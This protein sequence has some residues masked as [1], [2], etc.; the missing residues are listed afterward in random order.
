M[1]ISINSNAPI[2]F[3]HI[4]DN[5]KL[6]HQIMHLH[7]LVE[8]YIYISGDVDFIVEENYISLKTG[9]II[10]TTPNVLH[11]PIIKSSMTYE[12]FYIGIPLNAFSFINRGQNP[13]AF[14]TQNKTLI[15]A[16][17]HK[18]NH[19]ISILNHI[20][21]LLQN[22]NDNN[23]F[24]VYSYL[25]QFLNSLNSL[26]IVNEY[27]LDARTT[28]VPDIIKNVLKY[29]DTSS[30]SIKSVKDLAK[31]FYVNPSYLSSLF[32]DT[33]HVT[34]KQYLTQ[35]KISEAKNLLSGQLS[36]SDIAYE[37]GFSSCSHFISVFKKITGITPRE[38]RLETKLK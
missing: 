29:I 27:D 14:I 1:D 33:T 30:K 18:S 16:S 35:K 7:D 13:L 19:I 28:N 31:I 38:Y 26:F 3:N 10:I 25:L 17:D 8:I 9:D 23:F 5:P 15:S 20:S 4:I 11:T 22:K 2:L 24:L 32:S 37:C 34:L 36:I 21:S 12:R 6:S